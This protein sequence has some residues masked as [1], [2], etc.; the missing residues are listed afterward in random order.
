M[1]FVRVLFRTIFGIFMFDFFKNVFDGFHKKNLPSSFRLTSSFANKSL[2]SCSKLYAENSCVRR[3]V[4]VIAS[5]VASLKFKLK[6]DQEVL[7]SHPLISLLSSPNSRDSWSS[8]VEAFV[9][10]FVIYGNSY[11][12]F[13]RNDYELHLLRPERI[14][15]L[16]GKRGIPAGFEYSVDGVP[17]VFKNSDSSPVSIGH[18][19]SFNPFD[20]WYG[21]SLLDSVRLSAN[22]H[23]AITLHNLALIQNG[24]RVAGVI[25]LKNG[26]EPLSE[27][28]KAALVRTL[29]EQYQGA[30]N[31]GRLA[32]VEGADF[33]WKEMGTSPRDMDYISAKTL[34]A[35]E[36]S[37]ALGVPAIL[38]GGIGVTGES[39]RAN[40]KEVLERFN[41]GTVLPI[42]E[43]LFA[44]LNNW[45]VP[46]IDPSCSLVLDLES[47][48]PLHDKRL[49]L[50]EKIDSASF[51]S[52]KEKR[53][54]LGFNPLT[55][56]SPVDGTFP[57]NFKSDSHVLAD[58]VDSSN[59]IDSSNLDNLS[60]IAHSSEGENYVS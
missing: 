22:L 55:D 1:L 37:E 38:I 21:L 45:L 29:V 44:F 56:F 31:A 3:S 5:A 54:L 60:C 18:L 28:E 51:L 41:E 16:P 19:R 52:V 35:R 43:K 36:I 34:A 17:V 20:D 8:F 6:K 10:N 15:I 4:S 57:Q 46:Q 9:S 14:S 23:Q 53:Q 30:D 32:F 40:F 59:L 47:F 13:N 2:L 50:W 58:S 33:E 48:L 12:C 7:E 39:A 42:A 25:S 26:A 27:E 11:I 24:G 49:A